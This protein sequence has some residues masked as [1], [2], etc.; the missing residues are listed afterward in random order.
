MTYDWKK[1]VPITV[2]VGTNGWLY[3]GEVVINGVSTEFPIGVETTVPE[4]VAYLL[5]R[6]I[7]LEK[8]E[9][10]NTAKPNN[11]YVGD[12]TV[13][14][15]KT[16]VLEK[17]A[18]VADYTGLL[19]GGGG[20]GEV[21]D[22]VYRVTYKWNALFGQYYANHTSKEVNAANAT[23]KI[24]L[25]VHE[26][27]P[28]S[29]APMT[30]KETGE[31]EGM[32]AA[33]FERVVYDKEKETL[34]AEYAEL[35]EEGFVRLHT[36][37][38]ETGSAGLVVTIGP[39]GEKLTHGAREIANAVQNGVNVMMHLPSEGFTSLHPVERI[40]YAE[41]GSVRGATFVVKADAINAR[42]YV[43]NDKTFTTS[44]A[45]TN[46]IYVTASDNN[47][48]I[49]NAYLSGYD[50]VFK[51][52]DNDHYR[53]VKATAAEAVFVSMG[54]TNN[55]DLSIGVWNCYFDKWEKRTF[56]LKVST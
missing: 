33:V 45:D 37:T 42:V 53:L 50:V 41:D 34:K 46:R 38:P 24:C 32:E 2:P 49:L 12:V 3:S 36:V 52:A 51:H 23:G 14:E 28:V 20:D 5:E 21:V 40:I 29:Y 55:G 13:P 11:H 30:W 1:M 6:M 17:G 39:D 27:D 31:V 8:A 43:N 35:D 22:D 16:L 25:L 4:P 7:E 15:G 56:S 44:P 10:E 19:G 54:I 18:R 26:D 48:K 47:E 9:D